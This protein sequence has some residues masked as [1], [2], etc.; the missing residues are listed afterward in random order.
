VADEEEEEKEEEKTGLLGGG[1]GMSW[2]L[3]QWSMR[4]APSVRL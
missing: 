2:S 3:N 1:R 4:S